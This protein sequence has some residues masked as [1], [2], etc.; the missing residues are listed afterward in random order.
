M[1]P[2]ATSSGSVTMTAGLFYLPGGSS[3]PSNGHSSARTRERRKRDQ[4]AANIA[5]KGQRRA[6]T[7]IDIFIARLAPRHHP[8]GIM[9]D[10][11]QPIVPARRLRGGRYC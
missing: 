1:L 8:V 3:N 9:P 5:A 11:V 6:S 4:V 7:T 2:Q 10:L